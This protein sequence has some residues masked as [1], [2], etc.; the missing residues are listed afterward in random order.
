LF[1]AAAFLEGSPARLFVRLEARSGAKS[2]LSQ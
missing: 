2:G 1:F